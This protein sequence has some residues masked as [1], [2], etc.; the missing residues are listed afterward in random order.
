MLCASIRPQS[1]QEFTEDFHTAAKQ[2]V[3]L[4]EVRVDGF[5]HIPFDLLKKHAAS[6]VLFSM[7]KLRSKELLHKLADLYPGFLDVPHDLPLIPTVRQKYPKIRLIASYHDYEKTPDNLESILS[8]LKTLKA[9]YIKIVTFAQNSLDGVR[10]LSFLQKTDENIACFCMGEKGSFTR[11]LAP[12]YG[13]KIT[14]AC[15]PSKPTAEGQLSCD[16]LLTTYHFRKLAR[17]TTP[18]ALVGDPL[19]LSPSHI[20]HNALFRNLGQDAVYVKIPL[21][22]EEAQE[23]FRFFADLGFGGLSVTHP[24][25]RAFSDGVYNTVCWKETKATFC[26]TDGVGMLDAIEQHG[27]VFGKK[28]LLLGAGA[29]AYS[30]AKEAILRG[31]DLIITN[32]TE[33]KAKAV[34]SEL[35]CRHVPWNLDA[36]PEY[37]ILINATTVG[38]QGEKIGIREIRK[39]SVV[40]DCILRKDTDLLTL[41]AARGATIVRGLEMWL[42]QAAYQF[43]FWDTTLTY[44]KVLSWLQAI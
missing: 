9:D 3:D 19:A 36:L 10:L 12:L 37:D 35:C 31:A 41:A 38:M 5:S 27:A 13:S 14:Y 11:V 23:G 43:C 4:I 29:T 34:A 42:R 21:T 6:N 39:N 16:E 32:R 20:T 17:S 30:I 8:E 7:G 40:A 28:M 15:L 33:V 18:Y 24:L 1:E 44:E 22:K 2:G 25:K 26:N